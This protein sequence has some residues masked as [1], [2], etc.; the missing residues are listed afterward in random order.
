MHLLIPFAY[1]LAEGCASALPKLKL[2]QLEKLLARLTAAAPDQGDEFSLSTPHERALARALGFPTPDGLIPWAAHHAQAESGAAFITPCHWQAG[3][4]QIAMGEW[5][6][7]DFSEEESRA[8]MLAMQ[9]YFEEDGITLQFDDTTRWLAHSPVFDDIATASLDRV[10]GRNLENWM[11]RDANAAPLRRLQNEM[12]ML[13][14]THPVNE[15]RSSRSAPVVNSFWLS[16]TGR[17]NTTTPAASASPPIVI[18][19]LRQAALKE[20]WSSWTQ[21]WQ[22]VDANECAALRTALDQGQAVQI[23]LCGERHAQTF[24]SGSRSLLGQFK[25]FFGIQPASKLLKEL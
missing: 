14:Y 12:Q 22:Q 16:G 15:A 17:L 11:P 18:D 7:A 20:D 10:A 3:S 4:H 1:C 21:A 25:R 6:L 8:L 19:T 2:P 24:L 13:L 9:P 23:T 5:P